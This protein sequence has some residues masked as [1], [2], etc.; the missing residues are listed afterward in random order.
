MVA[1]H[2]PYYDAVLGGTE[3]R[4]EMTQVMPSGESRHLQI[5]F[6]PDRRGDEIVGFYSF[7]V[8]ITGLKRTEQ[9][10]IAARAA[11]DAANVA[12]SAFL[13]QMSHELRT[14][15]NAVIGFTEML[16]LDLDGNLCDR[17]RTYLGYIAESAQ[18]QLK[19]VQDLLD[20]TSLDIGHLKL[21]IGRVDVQE[22][23]QSVWRLVLPLAEKAGVVMQCIPQEL[24][25]V[26]ADRLRLNQILIN[27]ATNA[28]KYNRSGGWVRI[29][30]MERPGKRIRFAVAD[31]GKGIPRE[32][33]SRL[34]HPFEK[35]AAD[36]GSMDGVGLGLALVKR[37]TV[38]MG[39][40]VGF[41]QPMDVGSVFLGGAAGGGMTADDDDCAC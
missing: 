19:L 26:Q 9:Q 21:D 15:L 32:S 2:R 27:L 14:P 1:A 6:V 25:G 38:N 13:A 35:L 24:P 8:D 23:L 40:S 16:Q 29:E 33:E 30:A 10:L 4:F 34:F 11:A 7:G 37:L 3:Q 28:V 22:T 5:T 17:Q 39:G 41:E 18:H 36:H 31:N 20:F 12:K